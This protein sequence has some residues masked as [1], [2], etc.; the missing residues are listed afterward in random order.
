VAARIGVG[1]SLRY[2][3]KNRQILQ[4]LVPRTY[5]P[6][7]LL[8]S[9]G[10]SLTDPAADIRALHLFTFNQVEETVGWQRRLLQ[11]LGG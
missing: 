10:P 1:G 7:R 11:E 9:L 3:R 2:L 4:L 5:M 8:R 6:D